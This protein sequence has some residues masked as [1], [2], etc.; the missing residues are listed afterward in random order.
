MGMTTITTLH[1]LSL[2]WMVE[3][4]PLVAFACLT[5]AYRLECGRQCAGWCVAAE[6]LYGIYSALIG[7]WMGL[8]IAPFAILRTAAVA[9]ADDKWMARIAVLYGVIVWGLFFARA[10]Y[11]YDF[12]PVI[13]TTLSTLSLVCRN[14]A[15]MRNVMGMVCAAFWLGYF[16]CVGG[17][18]GAMLQVVYIASTLQASWPAIRQVTPLRIKAAG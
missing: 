18:G 8:M 11:L 16:A 15:L 10:E 9:W 1:G 13:A 7:A 14:H 2:Q 4:I 12:L 5:Y 6:V 3:A 17:V